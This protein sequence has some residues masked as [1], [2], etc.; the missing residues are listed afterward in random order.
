MSVL[1]T[2]TPQA[3]KAQPAGPFDSSRIIASLVPG[4]VSWLFIGV[5]AFGSAKFDFEEIGWLIVFVCILV[6]VAAT[7]FTVA[8]IDAGWPGRG[9]H[10]FAAGVAGFG[11][12]AALSITLASTFSAKIIFGSVTGTYLGWAVE[13]F[14][15]PVARLSEY[16]N[17]IA[18]ARQGETG[19]PLQQVT[20]GYDLVDA[21]SPR[22][23]AEG[24][25]RSPFE[26]LSQP[27]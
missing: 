27:R 16:L 10:I 21:N 1:P 5:V 13:V 11:V 19:I 20:T 14:A 6:Q 4:I 3:A 8:S 18:P 23:S 7:I 26:E 2:Q 17:R 24:E 15:R 25:R 12:A 9:K 22:N